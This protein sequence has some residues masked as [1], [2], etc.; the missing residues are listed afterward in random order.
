MLEANSDAKTADTG[1]C[2]AG[3]ARRG[4]KMKRMTAVLAAVFGMCLALSAAPLREPCVSCGGQGNA[5]CARCNGAGTVPMRSRSGKMQRA[6]CSACS[7][8][9]RIVCADCAG[10]GWRNVPPPEP[11]R[12]ERR[13]CAACNGRG[14]VECVQC[15]NSGYGAGK[16]GCTACIGRGWITVNILS[17][18][19]KSCEVCGGSGVKACY[20]C[21]GS[22]RTDCRS[23][24]GMGYFEE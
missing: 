7:G 10:R 2:G 20:K 11:R 4:M 19:R 24:N 18:E 12:P 3:C 15:W 21:G 6:V 5:V 17:G 8:Q 1:G 14:T 22:G 16:S 13:S 9:G 23:C